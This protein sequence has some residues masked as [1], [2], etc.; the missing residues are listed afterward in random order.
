[1]YLFGTCEPSILRS[2]EHGAN[3]VRFGL[4]WD[5]DFDPE[6]KACDLAKESA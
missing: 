5:E 6:E 1:M 2:Y 4:G 3:G